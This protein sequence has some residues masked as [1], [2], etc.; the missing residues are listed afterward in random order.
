MDTASITTEIILLGIALY[1]LLSKRPQYIEKPKPPP[2][3]VEV[4]IPPIQNTV[5]DNEHKIFCKSFVSQAQPF[6]DDFTSFN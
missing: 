5:V 4:I 3:N 1:L 2:P 6:D